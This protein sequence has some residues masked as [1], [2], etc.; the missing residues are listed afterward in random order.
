[1]RRAPLAAVAVVALLVPA[2]AA[3]HASLQESSPR[4]QARLEDP[5]TEIR[6]HYDQAV[7]ATAVSIDLTR[8]AESLDLKE[9]ARLSDALL[10][11]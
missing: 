3:A 10:E 2:G 9:F 11:L 5:P 8:R 1:M 7:T 4:E 6:L